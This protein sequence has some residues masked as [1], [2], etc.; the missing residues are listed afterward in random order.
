M[1]DKKEIKVALLLTATV[2]VA[3]KN[4]NFTTAERM[5]MYTSTLRYYARELG[6]SVPI[7]VVENSNADLSPWRD[8][9]KDSLDLTVMQFRP[10]DAEASKGF[11][12]SRGK[13][14]NEYLMIKKGLAQIA[15]TPPH[16]QVT[17]FMKLTGRYSTLNIH[18]MLRE[19]YRRCRRRD[20]V[21]MC[22]VKDTSLYRSL[23]RAMTVATAW[24]PGYDVTESRGYKFLQHRERYANGWC[25]SR[26]FVADVDYYRENIA[27]IYSEMYDFEYGRIA[28]HRLCA[29]SRR[30]RGDS[31]FVH[32]FTTQIL[33]DGIS[34]MMSSE[35]LSDPNARQDSP[36][37][38][39]WSTLRQNWRRFLPFIWI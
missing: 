5:A 10:D 27:D 21:F 28:E 8:E 13:G 3:V 16:Q 39:L 31:R 33:F 4:G 38:R 20:T 32:R 30:H 11:D 24:I 17:H 35:R 37:S 19:I 29:L 34:G 15:N 1:S 7:Y 22:D 26:F 2:E 12:P 18:A 23:C 14:Y 6:R 36:A 25:D 9:F